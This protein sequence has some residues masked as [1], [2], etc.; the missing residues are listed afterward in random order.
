MAMPLEEFD[1]WYAYYSLKTDEEQKALNKQKMS[2]KK[3]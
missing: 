1:L 2:L 3:R